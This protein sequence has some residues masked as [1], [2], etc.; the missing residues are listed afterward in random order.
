MAVLIPGRLVKSVVMH[1]VVLVSLVR[2][3]NVLQFLSCSDSFV[4]VTS[5]IIKLQINLMWPLIVLNLMRD[6]IVIHL[7]IVIYQE[8]V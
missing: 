4:K 1:G 8:S 2:V 6:S 7:V 3:A 5:C